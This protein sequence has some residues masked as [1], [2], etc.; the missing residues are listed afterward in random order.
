MAGCACEVR[1]HS[2]STHHPLN[3]IKRSPCRK[4]SLHHRL[5]PQ[6]PRMM[7][8]LSP[9]P[10]TDPQ[11]QGRSH[12]HL[13]PARPQR[14]RQRGLRIPPQRSQHHNQCPHWCVKRKRLNAQKPSCSD[15]RSNKCAQPLNQCY[16]GSDS[17]CS[18]SH[19]TCGTE[20]LTQLPSL[21]FCSP[22]L[23]GMLV[24]VSVCNRHRSCRWSRAGGVHVK[25]SL[26]RQALQLKDC[27]YD[28]RARARPCGRLHCVIG[29]CLAH[30]A[31]PRL[32]LQKSVPT[33]SP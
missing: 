11:T 30:A 7:K 14:G 3:N 13:P 1:I 4:P 8:L 12:R 24:A 25:H 6:R 16:R 32:H 26:S 5:A 33:L 21:F 23:D 15:L 10:Q 29:R 28:N 27:L 9:R 2:P 20:A 17:S 19:Q 18:M 22:E 31:S